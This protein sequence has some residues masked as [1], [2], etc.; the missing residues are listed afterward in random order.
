MTTIS[1]LNSSTI[2]EAYITLEALGR[3]NEIVRQSDKEVGWM[4]QMIRQEH[5]S[6][7]ITLTLFN[8]YVPRQIVSAATT[9]IDADGVAEY[10]LAVKQPELIKWW[11]HS[12]VNMGITP[13]G[14]D[15][16]TFHEHIENDPDNPF[17][18]TIHNKERL[19]YCNIYI[20][21]GLFV[22]DAALHV[23]WDDPEMVKSVEK[24]LKA[25]VTEKVYVTPKPNKANGYHTG[26]KTSKGKGKRSGS[27]SNRKQSSEPTK[28]ERNAAS[29]FVGF[30]FC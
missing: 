23:D 22:E 30:G 7:L 26:G 13:S 16:T 5:K 17:V 10:A 9:D 27:R 28:Q 4:G 25:N 19:T 3:V 11:G 12:H 18:M 1:I 15:M 14:T 8:P 21:G 24:E 20:G 29:N 6:G 2:P